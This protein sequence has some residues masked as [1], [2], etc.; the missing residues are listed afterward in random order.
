LDAEKPSMDSRTGGEEANEVLEL[1]NRFGIRIDD[2][3]VTGDCGS[4]EV[5]ETEL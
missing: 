5:E 3:G 4:D 2:V 1:E